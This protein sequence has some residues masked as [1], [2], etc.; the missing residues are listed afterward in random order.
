MKK[1]KFLFIIFLLPYLLY[2]QESQMPPPQKLNQSSNLQNSSIRDTIFNKFGNNS[3]KLNKNPDAKIQDYLIITKTFDSIS[4]DTSLTLNK[5]YKFNYLRKDNFELLPFSNTGVAY[6]NLSFDPVNSTNPEMGAM[7]KLISY[8]KAEDVVYYDLPTPFT[9]LMFRSVFEQ[10][11]LLDAVYSVNTSRHFNFS[12]SRKGLRSLGNYQNFISD[13]SNFRFTTNYHSKS[14]KYFLRT[15][16]NNQKLFSEQNGGIADVDISNFENGV[17]QFLDRGVFDP[18]FENAHNELIG[19]RFYIDQIYKFDRIDSINKNKIQI[20][21]SV[22]YEE[23]QYKF[24]QNSSDDFFGTAFSPQEINDKIFLT[25]LNFDTGLNYNSFLG[26]FKFGISFRDE[27]YSLKNFEIGEFIDSSQKIT[28][29]RVN[30]LAN[31]S[32]EL[33]KTTLSFETNNYLLG[34][35]QSNLFK[36][37]IKMDLKNDY[38][39]SFNFLFTNKPTNYNHRLYSSNYINYNWNNDFKNIKTKLIGL[40]LKLRKFSN[41]SIDYIKVNNLTQFE[42]IINENLGGETTHSIFPI[43]SVGNLELI[44]VRFSRKINFG[45]FSVDSKL[46]IQKSLADDII[47]LPEIISRN[48]IYYSSDMF[49]KALFLQTGLGFKYF[50]KF[51]MNGYD[52]LLSELYIQNDKKIGNFPVIDF[53]INAKI[54]QTRLFFKFEHLNSSFT[55]Y[56]FY[57]A[58]NY[59]YRDFTFRFGLVWNFFM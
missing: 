30:L 51:Y 31:F 56:N 2:A 48:T 39:L 49:K 23:K 28:S 36:S 5:Y 9:E 8:D 26:H 6:N 47:N 29:S 1:I 45:K 34:N 59:P 46:L 43:Q 19:K 50:S 16:Y 20:F 10:G 11:Q 57:S 24:Q 18:N 38:Q 40:D 17:N 15:H 14:G 25:S 4:V 12:I 37:D 35:S 27:K 42:K 13:N 58:P 32:K 7:N 22:L 21:N 53:F 41:I 44:K 55:G 33:K 3:A 54:Q 52:P